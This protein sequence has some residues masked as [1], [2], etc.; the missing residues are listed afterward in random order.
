MKY[1]LEQLEKYTLAKISLSNSDLTTAYITADIQ[2][3]TTLQE[4]ATEEMFSAAIMSGCGNLN[5]EQ[6]IDKVKKLGA[7]ISVSI[8]DGR[9]TIKLQSRKDN[10]SPLLKLAK[11]MITSPAFTKP[12][13]KRIFVNTKNSLIESK[14]DSRSLAEAELRNCFYSHK[15]R[16]YTFSID[17]LLNEIQ[18]INTSHLNKLHDKFLKTI[19]T[20]SIAGNKE[21][22]DD[23]TK[24]LESVKKPIKPQ[25]SEYIH[26]PKP[27]KRHLKLK[28]IPSKQNIDFS[29]G[30]PIPITLHHPDFLPLSLAIAVL[31]NWGG[32]AGRLMSTVREK[33]GLTYGIYAKLDGFTDKE[34]GYVRIMTFFAPDKAKEALKST[35]RELASL[36]QT[37]VTGEELDKFKNI[38]QT[39]NALR[40]DSTVSLLGELHAYHCLGFSLDEMQEYKEKISQVSLSEVNDAI[41]KYLE[42]CNYTVS[43]AGPT[44]AVQK[45][46]K[47][48]FSNMT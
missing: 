20:C 23:F 37:G 4:Q 46:L 2:R 12:E 8:N 44:Q 1:S 7:E 15:D 35:Y 19:W 27:L 18:V 33:E 40:K 14:E 38:L 25:V 24:F 29:I 26:E 10:F 45:D 41:K 22:L 5:R 42:P 28:N 47:S 21:Q 43:G 39:K 6:F 34:E 16:K 30:V 48:F 17:D 13:L 36:Y 32:F 9:L 11:L 3:E 31:G